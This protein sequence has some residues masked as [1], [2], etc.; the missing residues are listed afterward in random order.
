RQI[1]LIRADKVVKTI[2]IKDL[3]PISVANGPLKGVWVVDKR[4]KR[5]VQLDSQGGG[6]LLLR[7]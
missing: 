5:V 1:L 3:E 7:Q 4:Q 6:G 2:T